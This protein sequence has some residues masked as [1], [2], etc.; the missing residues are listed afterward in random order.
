MSYSYERVDRRRRTT[1]GGG[2]GASSRRSTLGYW[3][4]L[5]M[6]VTVATIGLAAWIWSERQ[7]DEDENS[8]E[9]K[10]P[11]S[12]P[13]PGYASMSGGLPPGP[14][15][16]GF[17]GPPPSAPMGPGGFEGAPI[18]PPETGYEGAARSTGAETQIPDDG[19][20]MSKMSGAL[21][22]TPSPQQSYDWAS[23]KV[24]A[25]VAAAGAMVGGALTTIREGSQDDYE[26]HE[27]WSEEAESRDNGKEI[28][29]GLKRRGTADDYFSGSVEMPK[30][31][32]LK[33]RR[34]KNV[35]VVVS[36]I[37]IGSDAVGEIGQ[38][39][40]ILAHLPEYINPETTR[41]FVLIYAPELKAHPLSGALAS[42]TGV[43]MTQGSTTSSFSNISHGDT[44]TPGEFPGGSQAGLAIVDPNPVDESSSLFKTLYNQAL[45][46]AERDTMILPFTT[47]AGHLHLLRSLAPELV[48]V[49][50][51][52]CGGEGEIASSLSGWVKQTVVGLVDT[53]D[54]D[55]LSKAR[56]EPWW[57]K[58]ER[59]GLGRSVAVVD[60]LKI[61]D[62]WKRRTGEHD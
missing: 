42:R 37:E 58:E 31:A 1:G 3:V 28:K 61:G 14:G 6:T 20:L 45:A 33:S 5:V 60:S 51:S 2:Y 59:T 53:E 29:R 62:D 15:P 46:V 54:E 49:Q 25:G 19:T 8:G 55:G 32:V 39:A 56:A 12:V 9:E 13:P 24:A 57:Q 41:V 11:G 17:Q 21:K 30:A 10:P 7:D 52:L 26:D 18:P 23:K 27:R 34:R 36:A 50:E 35:A 16:A 48:Y 38:H 47:R 4:P 22:R 40:S 44:H 43:P